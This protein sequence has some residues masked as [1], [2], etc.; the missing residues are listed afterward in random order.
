VTLIFFAMF[1]SL[2]FLTQYLQ[3]VLG[4]SAL[5]AG[6]G[7]APLAVT[8]MISAPTSARLTKRFGTKV[9]VTGG[10]AA[11]AGVMLLLSRV[12]VHSGYLPIGITLA[13]LG[14]GIGLAMSP[15]TESIMGSL[16]MAKAGVGSAVN[17]T[18][19][20]VGGAL[21]VA[22]LG[23]ITNSAYRA[24][25]SASAVMSGL[26][27]SARSV[28]RNGVGNALALSQR[29]G[30]ASA[31]ARLAADAKLAFVRAIT[32]TVTIGAAFAWAGAIVALLW[33]PAH[34]PAP[35]P[36]DAAGDGEPII[37]VDA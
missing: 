27:A 1:G 30:T 25:I 37:G 19:R 16:P 24:H 36:L 22:V 10:M 23:S 18:T 11:I 3:D 32:T 17:D 9:V 26:P 20:Q 7:F 31:A 35:A 6:L 4:Y 13:L 14:A 34:P 15:A 5:R 8:L 2:F 12:T 33:L 21:G 29:L 28:A